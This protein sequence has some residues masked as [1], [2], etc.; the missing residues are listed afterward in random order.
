MAP[1]KLVTGGPSGVRHATNL[2]VLITEVIALRFKYFPINF[3]LC[4]LNLAAGL[5]NGIVPPSTGVAVPEE[6]SDQV[7]FIVFKP[8]E[9]LVQVALDGVNTIA[10]FVG[11]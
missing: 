3:P 1:S 5:I 8:R 6:L 10:I 7:M 4:I 9:K 2:A 11:W